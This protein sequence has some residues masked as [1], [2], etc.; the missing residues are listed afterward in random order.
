MC[1]SRKIGRGGTYNEETE[2]APPRVRRRVQIPVLSTAKWSWC[3]GNV[4]VETI[5]N[6]YPDRQRGNDADVEAGGYRRI[7]LHHG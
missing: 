1:E 3:C 5:T 2:H 7:R 6:H 4:R